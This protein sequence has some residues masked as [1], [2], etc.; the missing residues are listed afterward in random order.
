MEQLVYQLQERWDD[1][2]Y[3]EL[4][5]SLQGL[6]YKTVN[7][8]LYNHPK[9]SFREFVSLSDNALYR[10]IISFRY[11]K[12]KFSTYF[13]TILKNEIISF[14]TSDNN[15]ISETDYI[16]E[17]DEE[18]SDIN[19]LEN[20]GVETNY[21]KVFLQ[22]NLQKIYAGVVKIL[23]TK[24]STDYKVFQK[25]WCSIKEKESVNLSEI[26]KEV[27]VTNVSVMYSIRRIKKIMEKELQIMKL[28]D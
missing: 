27:K 12:A 24:K 22:L 21:S 5:D 4:K 14:I 3:T 16:G 17:R 20:F 8:F 28:E 9:Y 10:A 15:V 2:V 19:V 25:L 26:A 1:N 18:D 13:T 6:I 23:K 7:S 11:G